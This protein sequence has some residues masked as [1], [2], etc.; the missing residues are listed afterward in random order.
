V[1]RRAAYVAD[2]NLG[3][4]TVDGKDVSISLLAGYATYVGKFTGKDTME[5]T[6]SNIDYDNGTWTATRLSGA[7]SVNVPMKS[8]GDHEGALK[9]K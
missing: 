4:Y 9:R 6:M 7:S 8:A 5:G 1:I 3:T 2:V